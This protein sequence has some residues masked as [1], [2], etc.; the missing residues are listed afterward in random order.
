MVLVLFVAFGVVI[1]FIGTLTRATAIEADAERVRAEVAV[2]QERVASGKDEIAFLDTDAFVEQ[3][4]RGIGY[5]ER[6]EIAI[7]LE[8]D[9]PS[10]QPIVPLG[11][12]S[13]GG[14]SQTPFD[15]W[16]ELL[17]GA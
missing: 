2:L 12:E 11:T 4:A 1:I 6:G 7:E 8:P 5:G 14:A 17:F 9:A 15:A 3:V 16:M 10:P 13:A